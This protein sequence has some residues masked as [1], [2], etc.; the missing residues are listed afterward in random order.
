MTGTPLL[1]MHGTE[2]GSVEYLQGMESYNALR[3]LKK[4]VIVASY[5]GED[6]HLAKLENQKDCM[7]RMEQFCDRYLKGAPAPDWMVHGVP[8]L[9]KGQAARARVEGREQ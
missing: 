7:S 8:F 4:P 1:H 2:D 3:F 5:P 6:H 9:K